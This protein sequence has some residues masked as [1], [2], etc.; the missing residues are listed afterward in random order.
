[1][2]ILLIAAGGAYAVIAVLTQFVSP[3]RPEYPGDEP[4]R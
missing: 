2:A 3:R 1:M 4:S